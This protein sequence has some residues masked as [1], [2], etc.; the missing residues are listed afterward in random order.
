LCGALIAPVAA[1]ADPSHEDRSRH[2]LLLSVEG[3]T[4]PT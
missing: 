4:R 3:C 1:V 2:V